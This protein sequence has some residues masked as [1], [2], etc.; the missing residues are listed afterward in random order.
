LVAGSPVVPAPK[1]ALSYTFRKFY[2]VKTL[3][4]S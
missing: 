3:V 2:S 4:R 1:V